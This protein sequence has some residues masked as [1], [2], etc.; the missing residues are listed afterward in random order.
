[1]APK[2]LVSLWGLSLAHLLPSSQLYP[3]HWIVIHSIPAGPGGGPP[4]HCRYLGGEGV[5]VLEGWL[6]CGSG[7]GVHGPLQGANHPPL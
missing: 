6:G 4:L 3:T 2:L 5:C 7:L 1:M